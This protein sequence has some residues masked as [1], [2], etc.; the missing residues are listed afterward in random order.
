MSSIPGISKPS[1]IL[2]MSKE[3]LSSMTID[4]IAFLLAMTQTQSLDDQIKSDLVDMQTQ[5]KLIADANKYL[6][7]MKELKKSAGDGVSTMPADMKAFL[8]ENGVSW[9]MT[10]PEAGQ[11]DDLHNKDEWDINIAYL[12]A[13]VKDK[14]S[15]VELQMLGIQSKMSKRTQALESASTLMKKSADNMESLIR[16]LA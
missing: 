16:N 14:N 8:S 2:T 4:T 10:G 15:S 6:A 1:D 13:F 7:Q 5:Q 12:D 9:D 11:T 3:Q